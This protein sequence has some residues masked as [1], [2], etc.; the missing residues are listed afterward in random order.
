MKMPSNSN[1]INESGSEVVKT[2]VIK[3]KE[4]SFYTGYLKETGGDCLA[5][6]VCIGGPQNLLVRIIGQKDLHKQQE[7]AAKEKRVNS[8]KAWCS[9]CPKKSW[10]PEEEVP[11]GGK[12]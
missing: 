1:Q 2:L 10:L 11:M 9:R 6:K 5:Y 3:I 12:K 8:G 4:F 7:G